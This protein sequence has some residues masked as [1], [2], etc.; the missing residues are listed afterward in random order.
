MSDPAMSHAF[1][2]LSRRSVFRGAVALGAGA[3]LGGLELPGAAS[4]AVPVPTIASCATWGARPPADPL[5]EISTDANKILI[6]HTATPNVTDYSQAH[7]YA[8]ARS[9]QNFHMDDNH[10]SDT[11]QHLTV[12]RGGYVMEGRHFS[13]AHLT[14]GNGMVVGAHCPGQNNQAIGIENEGTYTSTTPT[15]AQ[16]NKLVDLCAYICEQYELAPTKIYG[17]RDYVSTDCPGDAFYA[18]LPQLRLDVAAK[19]N[20]TPP[21]SVVIDNGSAGFRA[22]AAWDTSSFSAQRYGADYRFATPVGA[23][24]A[25]YFSAT[26]P[27]AANY[28]LETWYPADAGY[29]AATPFVVF[30]SGGN[31]TVTVNQQANG[32]GWRDL[33]TYA[34]GAGAR[35]LVAVSRWTSGTQYVIADAVRVTR[36]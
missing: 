5:T 35:D 32:G 19:L 29:N 28:R 26:L 13:L 11:G 3:A 25:A 22:S 21:F 7:A 20:G 1:P 34:F 36:V 16:W 31:K 12:S 9:I 18:R 30:A 24:D 27:A 10:W 17:H 33:G 6:H 2:S 15:T 14:S 23:S 4:A 8:L